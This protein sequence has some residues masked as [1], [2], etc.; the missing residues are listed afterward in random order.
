MK[1][2]TRERRPEELVFPDKPVLTKEPYFGRNWPSRKMLVEPH[3]VCHKR[4]HF[5]HVNSERFG[6]ELGVFQPLV[7]TAQFYRDVAM[8]PMHA[9]SY[10]RRCYDC[11]A[12]K[13]LP[14]DPVPLYLYPPEF[15]LTGTAAEGL[16]IAALLAIFP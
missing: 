8:F 10:P 4:L 12:G 14:G 13:C 11:S 2:E 7:S 3:F 1:Q 6:W 9:F 15:T 5:E 16:S